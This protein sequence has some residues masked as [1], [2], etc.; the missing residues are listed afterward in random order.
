MQLQCQHAAKGACTLALLPNIASLYVNAVITLVD[1]VLRCD[2]GQ[3]V[4][5]IALWRMECSNTNKC[6]PEMPIP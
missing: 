3:V 2:A 5:R 4:P 1:V 6:A